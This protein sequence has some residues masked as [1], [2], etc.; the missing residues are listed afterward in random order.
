MM[1][2][3]GPRLISST[4]AGSNAPRIFVPFQLSSCW[5]RLNTSFSARSMN[6]AIRLSASE[7]RAGRCGASLVLHEAG[8]RADLDG[9]AADHHRAARRQRVRFGEVARAHDHEAEHHVL[10]LAERTVGDDLVALDDRTAVLE[11]QAL[12]H[13]VPRL[14]E[15]GHPCHPGLEAL[16]GAFGSAHGL[17]RLVQ[18]GPE[19]KDEFAHIPPTCEPAASGQF[20]VSA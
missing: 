16:L 13:E 3:P 18:I 2:A 4:L 15:R 5:V 7:V 6:T 17:A 14:L 9:R 20:M 10:A 19:Q 8:D 1:F 12:V 11:W